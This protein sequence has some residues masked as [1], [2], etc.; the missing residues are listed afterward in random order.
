VASSADARRA[1]V[2]PGT[3]ERLVRFY[4]RYAPEKVAEV[5]RLL[6]LFA[7]KEEETFARLVAK[8]GAEPPADEA[9]PSTPPTP[10][11]READGPASIPATPPAAAVAS[12][13]DARRAEVAAE[14]DVI[15][16]VAS[17]FEDLLLSSSTPGIVRDD[18]DLIAAREQ[19]EGMS[20]YFGH[21]DA[22][23]KYSEALCF[24][25]PGPGDAAW[26]LDSDGGAQ[27]WANLAGAAGVRQRAADTRH[28]RRALLTGMLT[29]S[30]AITTVRGGGPTLIRNN[31]HRNITS[32]HQECVETQWK[33]FVLECES[34]AAGSRLEAGGGTALT[35]AA[36]AIR[37][38]RDVIIVQ[39][40]VRAL[41]SIR[42]RK[43]LNTETGR[44]Q[45]ERSVDCLAANFRAQMV[46]AE[47]HA[48]IAERRAER[49]ERQRERQAA[50]DHRRSVAAHRRAHS[51][52]VLTAGR[53]AGALK[54]AEI[55]RRELAANNALHRHHLRGLVSRE[56]RAEELRREEDAAQFKRL[57]AR[58]LARAS[59]QFN[60]FELM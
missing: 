11:P 20:R 7:G 59:R 37:N 8:Y 54:E 58:V 44:K 41:C 33:R 47:R 18:K 28:H 12:S 14:A 53:S 29:H 45:S 57:H 3:R 46:R 43:C 50:T 60:V 16:H 31:G 30:D 6:E 34:D 49:T 17:S 27:H 5:D 15:S 24:A 38:L 13:A 2:A 51:L 56:L 21:A 32:K 40:F 26:A 1:E 22:D 52:H 23:M 4:S 42:V 10:A 9:V 39:M 36:P 48:C 19:E 55:F 35:E 25:Y